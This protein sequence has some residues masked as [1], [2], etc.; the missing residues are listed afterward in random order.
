MAADAASPVDPGKKRIG[1]T[2]IALGVVSLLMDISSEMAYTQVPIFLTRVLGA[3]AELVGLIEGLAE[4]T[5]SLL[6]IVAGWISDRMGRRKPLALLGYTLGAI[7]KPLIAASSAWP[8]VLG[9]RFIDRLGKGL[10]SAPRDALIAECTDESIRG[11]AFGLHRSMDTIGAILGPLLGAWILVKIAGS[12]DHR[13]RMLFLIAA[14]PGLLSV[15]ALAAIVREKPVQHEA[16]TAPRLPRLSDLSPAFRRYL[17]VVLIFNLGNSS[18]AFLIL[19]AVHA[20]FSAGQI[21]QLYALFNVTEALL[22]YLAGKLSDRVG[23]KPLLF[24]GYTIF[25]VVYFGMAL[26]ATKLAVALL[27]LLY[28]GYYTLTQGPQRALAADLA[29]PTQRAAQIGAY[30]TVV[31]LALL[32][33]SLIAGRLFEMQVWAPFAYG[34]IMA[35]IALALL[36]RVAARRPEA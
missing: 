8:F 36:P 17:L 6:R 15:L 30:Y 22:G 2:V 18:D 5:A 29:D 31:G 3:R 11:R 34:G 35:L 28:G 27:F 21:L 10:R 24:G 25:A 13:L 9:A 14:I 20:G 12:L 7:S 19:R 23:R 1:A 16:G 33:A 26:A 4:S 32:P